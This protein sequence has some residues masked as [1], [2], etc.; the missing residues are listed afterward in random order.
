MSRPV[1][2]V[3]QPSAYGKILINAEYSA[4]HRTSEK[5]PSLV[6]KLFVKDNKLWFKAKA[7]DLA[8]DALCCPS[9]PI[10]GQVEYVNGEWVPIVKQLPNTAVKRDVPQASV[11]RIK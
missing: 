3:L 5:F 6:T 10:I 1:F 11:A 7:Y 2:V 8:K 4:P 9:M